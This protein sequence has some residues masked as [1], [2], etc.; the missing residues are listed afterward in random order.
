[1][2][3][4]V[5]R[6]FLN[7]MHFFEYIKNP[8]SLA[9]KGF[10]GFKPLN[11]MRCYELYFYCISASLFHQLPGIFFRFGT[12]LKQ[13]ARCKMEN[14][15]TEL[16]A[17]VWNLFLPVFAALRPFFIGLFL[18]WFLY[19]A[20]QW[21]KP[22][23][24]VCGAITATYAV[25]FL[26]L[27]ATVGSF[28]I[29]IAG[30]LPTGGFMDTVK[31]VSAY[32]QEAM[33]SI[34]AF[35]TK[36]LPDSFFAASDPENPLQRWLS[37]KI[38]LQSLTAAVTSISSAAVNLFLGIIASIYLLKDRDYFLLLWNRFLSLI[39]PQ[40]IHGFV[41]E[42]LHEINAILTA[43]LK[44]ALIDSLLVALL[45]SAALTL[46]QI[47]FAVIIGVLG[48]LLNIIPYFGP[49]IGMVPAFFAAFFQGGLAKS[50]AAV[51]SLLLVQQ[52]DSNFL[53]PHIVGTSTGLH[54]LFVLL[55][56]SILGYFFGL[57]GMLLAVP[58]AAILQIFIKRWA[59][60]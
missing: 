35:C 9:F 56:I 57:T 40:K 16:I 20:V 52:I 51:V 11:C 24:G 21:L 1:M 31:I 23:M 59:F 18:A 38:S 28:I 34:S 10:Q 48:G 53:Y 13:K 41:S 2:Y 54:P 5:K 3:G 29:L 42:L 14:L 26:S 7:S 50:I 39:L 22:R 46:L 32:F 60:R 58:S 27:A 45:S 55:S 43:F 6:Y 33:Q 25:F 15:F 12:I 8:L 36:Y 44:G 49:F 30:T 37:R 4:I 19:P 47:D 17:A